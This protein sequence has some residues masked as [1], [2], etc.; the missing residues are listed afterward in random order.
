MRDNAGTHFFPKEAVEQVF[1][2]GEGALREDRIAQFLK[3]LHDLVIQAG[4]VMIDA[5]QHNDTDTILAL[6]LI[7]RFAGLMTDLSLAMG[8]G[9]KSLFD[10]AVI[11][12][13]GET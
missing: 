13:A 11:F 6:Q 1:V 7:E 3:L 2:Q 10:S 12:F 8:E 5:A 9:F 4:V